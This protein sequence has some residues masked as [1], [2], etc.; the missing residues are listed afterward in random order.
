MTVSPFAAAITASIAS[1]NTHGL[2]HDQWAAASMHCARAFTVLGIEDP[3]V[4]SA[5][6]LGGM[7][8]TGP[9]A[10]SCLVVEAFSAA[11]T[12]T[13]LL[14]ERDAA[15]VEGR[16]ALRFATHAAT[17]NSRGVPLLLLSAVERDLT[18]SPLDPAAESLGVALENWRAAVAAVGRGNSDVSV[19]VAVAIA[20]TQRALLRRGRE[21]LSEVE[22]NPDLPGSVDRLVEGID[23]SMDAWS[24]TAKRWYD[25]S[26]DAIPH[27]TS[28]SPTLLLSLAATDLASALNQQSSPS[29]QLEALIRSGFGGN[30]IA[31]LVT[32]G[33]SRIGSSTVVPAAVRL[34]LVADHFTDPRFGAPFQD[35]KSTTSPAV[36]GPTITM[37]PGSDEAV[38]SSQAPVNSAEGAPSSS[39]R[40]AP[41]VPFQR[42]SRE[43]EMELAQRRDAGII[44]QAALDGDPTASTLTGAVAEDELQDLAAGGR[45]AVAQLIASM[46]PA[47]KSTNRWIPRLERAD[48]VQSAA[49]DVAS[50]A[51]RWDP[52]KGARWLTFAWRTSWWASTDTR[53]ELDIRPIPVEFTTETLGRPLRGAAPGP[54]DAL[55]RHLDQAEQRHL[56]HQIR[57]LDNDE[58]RPELLAVVLKYHGLDGEPPKNFT[59]IAKDHDSST[60]TVARRYR[61]AIDAL[62]ASLPTPPRTG[63]QQPW[64]RPE[65]APPRPSASPQR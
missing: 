52:Q 4:R 27:D 39:G 35:R 49:L 15:C 17:L 55:M 26:V 43:A 46:I 65:N 54:E 60:S 32:T 24:R 29:L 18:A 64:R 37:L 9:I 51:A 40:T 42:L 12:A 7:I 20:V 47:M 59:Q 13:V 16:T 30:M 38:V 23:A 25:T 58:I 45:A 36:A 56:M 48:A 50:A 21:L 62:R 28:R 5:A 19:H 6:A 14:V 53:K 11:A 8:R 63:E 31:G 2:T 34:E 61:E 22:V 41:D 1:L 33:A 10:E 3:A 57:T 44:A